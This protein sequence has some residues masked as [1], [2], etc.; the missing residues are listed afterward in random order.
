MKQL[1]CGCLLL[2]V[3]MAACTNNEKSNETIDTL[4][5]TMMPASVQ[6]VPDNTQSIHDSSQLRRDS[7]NRGDSMR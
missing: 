7:M 3:M 4:Q 5:D 1:F 2:G 6:P